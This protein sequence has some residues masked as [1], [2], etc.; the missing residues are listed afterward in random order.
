MLSHNCFRKLKVQ[1]NTCEVSKWLRDSLS[2]VARRMFLN[3]I[4]IKDSKWTAAVSSN[5]WQPA[6]PGQGENWTEM[7][8]F[9]QHYWL[10]AISHLSRGTAIL[11]FSTMIYITNVCVS[12]LEH[13]QASCWEPVCN[14]RES[15]F[16]LKT[17]LR[18]QLLVLS[19][20]AGSPFG[21]VCSSVTVDV[22]LFGFF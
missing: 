11:W 13:W 22:L 17:T 3:A 15:L 1:S 6:N 10:C 12:L 8:S 16:T 18:D 4:L 5:G 21:E 7:Y 19:P 20:V 14:F 2:T 9:Y